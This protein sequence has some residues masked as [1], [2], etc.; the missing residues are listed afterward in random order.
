MDPLYPLHTSIE[1]KINY[2]LKYH[3]EYV[4]CIQSYQ[5]SSS[6]VDGKVTV[7]FLPTMNIVSGLLQDG[8]LTHEQS[9]KVLSST[10]LIKY[11]TCRLKY[12]LFI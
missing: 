3:Y 6:E 10:S 8:E 5:S 1:K 9:I 12:T 2:K 11:S 4:M 7:A